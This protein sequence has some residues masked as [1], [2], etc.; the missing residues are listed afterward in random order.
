MSVGL[1][2]LTDTL[3]AAP[4]VNIWPTGGAN[5][6]AVA[7]LQ[8]PSGGSATNF[9]EQANIAAYGGS[10]FYTRSATGAT[11]GIYSLVGAISAQVWATGTTADLRSFAWS[12]PSRLWAIDS[13]AGL[14]LGSCS[15]SYNTNASACT[16]TYTTLPPAAGTGLPATGAAG[17]ISMV[18]F[19]GSNGVTYIAVAQV[20][21]VL[22]WPV[23]NTGAYNS[24]TGTCCAVTSAG[25]CCWAWW[26]T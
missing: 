11:A 17:F 19:P 24:G 1:L 12:S 22:L 6:S 18:V 26:S 20:T 21:G 23:N 8:I 3:G 7:Y 2:L 4:S 15:G 16:T 5:S 14:V 10:V 13:A 9:K 25:A